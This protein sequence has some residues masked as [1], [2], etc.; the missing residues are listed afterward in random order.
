MKLNLPSVAAL[1]VF[2]LFGN[3]FLASGQ[4]NYG[5]Q[6]NGIVNESV[7]KGNTAFIAGSFTYAGEYTGAGVAVDPVV[8]T[9]DRSWPLFNHMVMCSVDDGAGGFYA[10]GSFSAVGGLIRYGLVHINADKSIDFSFTTEVNGSVYA[11]KRVGSVLYIG[12][13]FTGVSSDAR[14]NLAALD[15]NNWGEVLPWAPEPNDVVY[16]IAENNGV[17]YAGGHFTSIGGAARNY[18]AALDPVSGLATSWNPI[19]EGRP[20]FIGSPYVKAI[21]AS[22]STIYFGGNF[23]HVNGIA[24]NCLAAVYETTGIETGWDPQF[25]GSSLRCLKLSGF[26]LYVGGGFANIGGQTRRNCGAI[27][28]RVPTGSALPFNPNV[29]FEVFSFSLST[30]N[31]LYIG[32]AFSQ[33]G[34]QPREKLAAVDATSGALKGWR[35]F[36]GNGSNIATV[37]KFG[38]DVFVGGDFTSVG[39]SV[40]RNVA[41]INL[42]DN[43]VLPWTANTNG[44]VRALVVTEAGDVI[45]GGEFSTVNGQ[46]RNRL[47]KIDAAGNLLPWNPGA[48]NTVYTLAASLTGDTIYVGGDFL[49]AGGQSRSRIAAIAASGLATSWNPGA[50]ARVKTLDV[51]PSGEVYA[52]GDFDLV[53]FQSRNRLA[54]ISPGGVVDAWNP[55]INGSVHTVK[56]V[57]DQYI[58]IGGAFSSAGG[59]LRNNIAALNDL[60]LATDWDPDIDGPV[61]DLEVRWDMVYAAGYFDYVEGYPHSCLVALTRAEDSYTGGISDLRAWEPIQGFSLSYV[62]CISVF[63]DRAIIGGGYITTEVN[64]LSLG[65]TELNYYASAIPSL[66]WAL[67]IRL[68]QFSALKDGRNVFIRWSANPIVDGSRFE[69]QRKTTNSAFQTIAS[70][71]ADASR[72]GSIFLVLDKNLPTNKYY[73]RLKITDAPGSVIYSDVRVISINAPVGPKMLPTLLEANQRIVINLAESQA[74]FMLYN[75]GGQLCKRQHLRNGQQDLTFTNLASGEIYFYVIKNNEKIIE[76]GKVMIR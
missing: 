7:V 36:I 73:Y 26:T 71:P 70:L 40:R 19:I 30:D 52:G 68:Q 22:G 8:G 17:I 66:G 33:V 2:L 44:N 35:P 45:I 9:W 43:T 54:R 49:N 34:G 21:E 15:L 12:G 13:N 39:G 55:N 63:Y 46:P 76:T 5:F 14:Q 75:R 6:T 53:A 16:T 1:I 27:D 58:Y 51:S 59:A 28:I 32:G 10:G 67:P 62:N 57:S 65:I 11:L 72:S 41:A 69:L 42:P 25:M 20:P 50:N 64:N 23:S 56:A 47:A 60:G 48:D 61:N 3:C 4:R 29:N 18:V 38:S 31:V 24:R 74:D 37:L